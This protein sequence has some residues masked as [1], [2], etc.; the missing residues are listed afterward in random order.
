MKTRLRFTCAASLVL[1]VSCQS[2]PSQESSHWN[3]NSV[4]PRASYNFLGYREDLSDSYRDQLWEDKQSINLTVKRHFMNVNPENPFQANWAYDGPRP[5]HSLLPNP[6]NYMHAESLV[7]GGVLAAWTGTFLPI[8]VGSLIGT[9]LP[10]GFAEFGEGI[11]NTLSGSFRAKI[12]EPPA[13]ADFR[14]RSN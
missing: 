8:P 6:W 3:L 5:P 2:A 14:V 12:D 9:L 10:G 13:V 7:I 11:G 1:A 4:I